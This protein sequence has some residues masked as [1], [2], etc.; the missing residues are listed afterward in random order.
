MCFRRQFSAY[1]RKAHM[2]QEGS[3]VCRT[4]HGSSVSSDAASDASGAEIDPRVRLSGTFFCEVLVM[5]YFSA[6]LPL[7]LIQLEQLSVN[8]ER[9]YAK[10]W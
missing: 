2:M 6:I 4:G 10:Y 9:M 1:F 7:P 5:Q 3:L 8:G